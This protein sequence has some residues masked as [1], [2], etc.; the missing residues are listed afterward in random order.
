MSKENVFD[1]NV[2]FDRFTP[3]AGISTW[4]DYPHSQN[5][6]DIK[7][8][9]IVTVGVP[10]DLGASNRPGARFAPRAMRDNSKYAIE[11]S[12]V[13]PWDYDIQDACKVI[14]YGDITG[15]VGTRAT[16]RMLEKTTEHA[17]TIYENGAFT[18]ALGGDHTIPYGFI[19]AAS[20]KYG[21]VALL[22]FDAHQ[23]SADS[24]EVDVT[25]HGMF[26]TDLVNEG[27][28]DPERSVQVFQRTLAPNPHN[29]K[30]IDA[31]SAIGMGTDKM[32]EEVKAVAGDAPVYITFD[33]DAFDNSV[34]PATGTPVPGGPDAVFIRRLLYALD[35]LN[36]VGADIVEVSPPYDAPALPT[37]NL[38]TFI[39][40]DMMYLMYSTRKRMGITC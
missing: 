32:A 24:K 25:C 35:G 33:I 26:S 13:Y 9:D 36:V 6:E 1:P 12:T 27:C 18:L 5:P 39:A 19:R 23:D 38:A 11:Y 21:K 15:F 16:E 2:A 20:A 37:V 10:F 30:I 34:A 8:A 3:Y 31:F 17:K 40:L 29:Y 4:C 22:H 28:I 14:D 7:K